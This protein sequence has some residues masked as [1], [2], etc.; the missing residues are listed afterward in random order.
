MIPTGLTFPEGAGY[1][2]I[3]DRS[4]EE[5]PPEEKEIEMASFTRKGIREII[6]EAFT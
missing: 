2:E 4:G 5:M 3:R 6:G 1:N